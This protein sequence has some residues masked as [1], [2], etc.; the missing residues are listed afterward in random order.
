MKK[1][2]GEYVLSKT[3]IKRICAHTRAM[4]KTETDDGHLETW[5]YPAA[6]TFNYLECIGDGGYFVDEHDA[7]IYICSA[8]NISGCQYSTEGD[9][10]KNYFKEV[11]RRAQSRAE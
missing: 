10:I 2:N 6:G 5:F 1:V 9:I 3:D 7:Y 11:E 8:D 4:A